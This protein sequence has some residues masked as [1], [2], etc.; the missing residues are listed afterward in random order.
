ML[1]HPVV[2][3]ARRRSE[4][5]R[6]HLGKPSD[7]DESCA[8]IIE[9]GLTASLAAVRSGLSAS[10]QVKLDEKGLTLRSGF[11]VMKVKFCELT[12]IIFFY[13]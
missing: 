5:E 9:I 12:S 7:S 2:R 13:V 1:G 10:V 8:I 3:N 4:K 6:A 11:L